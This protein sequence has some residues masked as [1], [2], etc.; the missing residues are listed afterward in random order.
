MVAKSYIYSINS[1]WL[2]C[3]NAVVS[4]LVVFF[5]V[6]FFFFW[7]MISGPTPNVDIVL[8]ICLQSDLQTGQTKKSTTLPSQRTTGSARSTS[9]LSGSSKSHPIPSSASFRPR[10]RQLGKRKDID[11]KF[12]ALFVGM[13]FLF[14]ILCVED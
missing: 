6:F 5:M 7:L 13:N 4:L 3:Q 12:P 2:S 8:S 1:N 10:D 14:L 11:S 9:D